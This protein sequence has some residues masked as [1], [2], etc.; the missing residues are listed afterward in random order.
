[1]TKSLRVNGNWHRSIAKFHHLFWPLKI[2]RPEYRRLK[3]LA[4][5]KTDRCA[6]NY[7]QL[8]Y[9]S[10]WVLLANAEF[11]LFSHLSSPILGESI[12]LHKMAVLPAWRPFWK[13]KMRKKGKITLFCSILM[14]WFNYIC[15]TVATSQVLASC[16]LT[17]T[18]SHWAVTFSVTCLLFYRMSLLKLD[19][20]LF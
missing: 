7:S 5:S 15:A 10:Y 4:R 20:S 18:F 13:L 12:K 9:L 3:S 14:R 17:G 1:M 6:L 19:I 8:V 2:E 16:S 11:R